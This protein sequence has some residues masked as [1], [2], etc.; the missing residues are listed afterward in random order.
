M[1][2]HHNLCII[3]LKRRLVIKVIFI[4]SITVILP[5][6]VITRDVINFVFDCRRRHN[7]RRRHCHRHRRCHRRRHCFFL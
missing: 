7:R 2:N 4:S 1:I 3:L 6:Y 5:I